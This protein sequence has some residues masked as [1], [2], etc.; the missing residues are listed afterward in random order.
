MFIKINTLLYIVQ[1][2][3]HIIV[4]RILQ[5]TQRQTLPLGHL[6]S[7]IEMQGTFDWMVVE[8]HP[9]SVH[10]HL[11]N[12][13]CQL[14][15]APLD[16]LIQMG[17]LLLSLPDSAAALLLTLLPMFSDISSFSPGPCDYI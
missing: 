13:L 17:T 4:I 9:I 2:S 8:P 3:H 12:H 5:R 15:L 10:V 1:C 14:T 7:M 11:L 16:V 6:C